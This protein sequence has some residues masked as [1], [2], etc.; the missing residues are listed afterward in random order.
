MIMLE[1]KVMGTNT[2]LLPEVNIA[3][4][5]WSYRIIGIAQKANMWPDLPKGVLY[6]HM[7]FQ[8]TLFIAIC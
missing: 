6:T 5:S 1:T 8:D 4:Y 3:K 7:Q 2:Q